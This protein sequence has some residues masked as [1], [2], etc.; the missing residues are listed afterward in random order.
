MGPV[1]TRVAVALGCMATPVLALAAGEAHGGGEAH[2]AGPG[3]LFWYFVNFGLLLG[4]L[5]WKG[6]GPMNQF[7]LERKEKLLADLRAAERL[8]D[9][10]R[11]KLA[12]VEGR[13]AALDGEVQ[14]ILEETL[15]VAEAERERILRGAEETAERIRAQATLMVEQEVRRARLDLA[16]EVTE[17]AAREAQ[18]MLEGAVQDAD[19]DRMI[20]EF[21][22][23]NGARP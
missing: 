13:L 4:L 15:R 5:Y 23:G 10:A 22:E 8:R 21:T 7:L 16:R 9:E 14:S 2:A 17:I 18:T 1:A 11:A 3:S 19:Q 12:E 6:R 20:H